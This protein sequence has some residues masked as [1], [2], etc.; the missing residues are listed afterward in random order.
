MV[1]QGICQHRSYFN[2]KCLIY[3]YLFRGR[4]LFCAFIDYK[5][6]FDSVNR[7]YLW[8]KLH[9]NNI[10]GKMFKII[11]NMYA[12]A[13]SSVRIGNL[14][15][16][17]FSSNS[18]VLQGENLSPAHAYNGLN[19]VSCMAHILLS[20]YIEVY[21]KLYILLYADDTVIF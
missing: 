18:G 13:K 4:K 1:S 7:A 14:K 21:F 16:G 19:N 12:N 6:A 20:N 5:K 8:L 2:L 17:S 11:H 15:S 9:S 10:D 3:L